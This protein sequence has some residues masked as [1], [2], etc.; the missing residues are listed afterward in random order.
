M[1]I[2]CVN[3]RIHDDNGYDRGVCILCKGSG[4]QPKAPDQKEWLRSIGGGDCAKHGRWYGIC[5]SC[6]I[7]QK[8]QDETERRTRQYEKISTL[9]KENAHLRQRLAK[10]E[11]VCEDAAADLKYSRDAQCEIFKETDAEW[12]AGCTESEKAL[13]EKLAAWRAFVEGEK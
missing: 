8:K 12:L 11:A 5:H 13:I 7:D 4:C 6:D 2:D 9:E 10:A 1:S 3:G